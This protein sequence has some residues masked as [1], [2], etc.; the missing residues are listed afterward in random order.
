MHRLQLEILRAVVPLLKPGGSLVYSTCSLEREEN[1][2]V[3][4]TFLG[5]ERGFRLTSFEET[6]PFRDSLDGAFAARLE[7]SASGS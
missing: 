7:L 2:E 4:E 3:I 6:L 5:E 1:A